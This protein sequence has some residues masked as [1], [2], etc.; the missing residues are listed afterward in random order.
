MT[1]DPPSAEQLR[2]Q[3][4]FWAGEAERHTALAERM[5]G[6]ADD[7]RLPAVAVDEARQFARTSRTTAYRARTMQR[8]IAQVAVAH[9]VMMA[10][11]G[12]DNPVAR[13]EYVE[14]AEMAKALMPNGDVWA[15]GPS[16][17]G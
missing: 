15:S 7:P 4:A 1:D 16:L 14:T 12:P 8:L 10:A 3:V 5:D 9:D 11:G 6:I 2:D 13:A 17:D